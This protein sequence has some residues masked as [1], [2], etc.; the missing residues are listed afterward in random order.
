MATLQELQTRLDN[1]TFDPSALNKEQR[2]AVDNAFKSGQLKGYSSVSEIEKERNIASRVI[3][4]E[5]EKKAD[6]FKVATRGMIPFTDEGVERSDLELAGDVTG[7]A[8]VYLKDAKKITEAFTRDPAAGYGADKLRAAATDFDKFEKAFQRLPVIKGVKI[9]QKTARALGK[10]ADG[11]RTVSKAPTQLLVTEAKSQLAGAGGA[12]AGSVLYDMANVATDFNVAVNKDLAAISDNDIKKLPYA[13]QVAVHSAEA[14]RNAL[15][16]NLI[17]SSLAPILNVTLRGM[18]GALGLGSPEAKQ[19]AEAAEKQGIKLSMSTLADTGSIGGRIIQGFERVFGVIP[20]VNVFAK[21]QRAAVEKQ[22]FEAFIDQV[23]SKAP[24]EHVGLMNLKFLPTMRANFEQYFNM[25]QQ[26]YALVDTIAEKMGNPKFIPTAGMKEAAQNF[27]TKMEASLP[28][29]VLGRMQREGQAYPEFLAAKMRDSG[30]DDS[31]TDIINK[32]RSLDDQITPTEYQGLMRQVVNGMSKSKMSDIRG[33]FHNVMNAAREDFNKVADPNNIQGYLAS[34]N[35]KE[36]YQRILES[37]GEQAAKEYL[38]KIQSGMQDFGKQLQVANGFFSTVTSAFNSPIAKKIRNSSENVFATKGLLGVMPEGRIQPDEIWEKT[39]QQV[40]AKPNA[41]SMREL[42]FILGVDNPKNELGKQLFN[43]ARSVYL[44]EALLNSYTKQPMIPG[45]TMGDIMDQAR[46][47]GVID[48]K[49]NKEIFDMAGTT[50]LEE[51][52]RINPLMADRYNLGDVNVRDIKMAAKDAG[53][54]NIKLFKEQLGLT[55]KNMSDEAAKIQ[56]IDKFTEMY[57][58]GREGKEAARNLIQLIDIMDKEY[59]KYISDSNSYLMRRIMLSGAGQTAIGGGF[60]AGA[61][62]SGGVINALPLTL[63]LASG[64]YM[65]ASPK[66]LKYMLDVYTDFERLDKLGKKVTVANV[67]KSMFRL[68]NWASEEDKDFP[69]VDP[70]K[71]NFEEVTDYLLT[72]NILIPELGFSPQ[73]VNKPQRD[74]FFPELKVVDRS[75]E[76]QNSSGINFLNGSLQ[77]GQKAE[78]VV[79]FQPP[80]QEPQA[81]PPGS[82]GNIPLN[83]PAYQGLV[84]PQYLPQNQMNAQRQ[85]QFQSLFPNDALGAA[86]SGRTQQ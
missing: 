39:I 74:H 83:A 34:R 29:E 75:S 76:A 79:N 23:L 61:A 49:G 18:K 70:K 27:M 67:P 64:G 13:Q 53:E 72:K 20:L 24:L 52:K 1:K 69:D 6:P 48:Y 78:Q 60:L 33:T 41:G 8:F 45:K 31:F 62:A 57:G 5:K 10:F 55:R 12:G 9:L 37:N 73:A 51:V 84:A 42:K 68:L 66:S 63:M 2:V 15:Y 65:L 43:R 58:G 38:T 50:Q 85:Q 3:A 81:I 7:S 17:G 16:F 80:A 4:A 44:T 82:V 56:A 71:I 40:F 30:F 36:E 19:L 59:G 77:G 28:P 11:F 25:I 47:L 21:K 86:I 22:T 14:M 32:V 54:F 26:N 35:F 46:E